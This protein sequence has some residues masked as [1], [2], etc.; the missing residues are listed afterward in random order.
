MAQ[1]R[2]GR[3]DEAE[4]QLQS[5]ALDENAGDVLAFM[6][7]MAAVQSRVVAKGIAAGEEALASVEPRYLAKENLF[8]DCLSWIGAIDFGSKPAMNFR[9]LS[10][11][12]QGCSM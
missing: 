6:A 5:T 10:W 9:R 8:F 7:R 1:S 4:L 2:L 12:T 11:C 3:F